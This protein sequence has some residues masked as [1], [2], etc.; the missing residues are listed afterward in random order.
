LWIDPEDS[1]STFPIAAI[2][3]EFSLDLDTALDAMS[4]IG[5]TGAELRLIGDR[6]MIDLGDAEVADVRRRVEQRGM[7]VLSI[8]SPVLKCVLP[9]APPVDERLEQDVFG[10]AYTIDDQPRL[11]ERAFEIA[12]ITGATIIRVF[13]YWRTTAPER[14]LDRIVAALKDLADR[15]ATRGLI[16]GLENE[17]A[18]NVGTGAETGRVLAALDHPAL[19]AI[20]DPA[21]ASILGEIPFPDGYS[22]L[23]ASRIVHVHAK[24]CVVKGYTPTWGALGTMGIDW[25]GQLAALKR[26]GYRGAISLET[27]WRTADGDRLKPSIICGEN[28]RDLVSEMENQPA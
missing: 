18:C 12:E 15:A 8:A 16:I 27:H 13:S 23:P 10:S 19:K 5:M 3:D 9:D 17:Q 14:C 6:N 1:V 26:D 20:W 28:L 24:D 22:Q 25:R 11:S 7:R 21:N 2:T 4:K